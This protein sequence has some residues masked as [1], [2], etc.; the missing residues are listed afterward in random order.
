MELQADFLAG[1]L[2][3]DFIGNDNDPRPDD[4]GIDESF[5]G[6]HVAG[7]IAVADIF[8]A[9][10]ASDRPYKPA[11]PFERALE[12]L[13]LEAGHRHERSEAGPAP[14]ALAEFF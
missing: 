12:I 11:V 13:D 3:Y 6:T 10:T 4:P 7:I 9:L 2:G 1:E 5:H 14:A 8:D